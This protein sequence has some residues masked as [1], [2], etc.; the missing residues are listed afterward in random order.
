MQ[1][2]RWNS[3][4]IGVSEI[5]SFYGKIVDIRFH[6][7]NTQLFYATTSYMTGQARTFM[8]EKNITYLDFDTFLNV[9]AYITREGFFKYLQQHTLELMAYKHD[10]DQTQLFIDTHRDVFELLKQVRYQIASEFHVPLHDVANS[11]QLCELIRHAP[12]TVNEFIGIGGFD[13]RKA[14]LYG[15]RFVEVFVGNKN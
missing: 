7:P 10:Q 2:K 4:H 3:R 1:C 14:A 5:A 13:T 9:D 12:L 8:A 6:H 11:R 15:Q